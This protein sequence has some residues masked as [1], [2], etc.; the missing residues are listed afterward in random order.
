MKNLSRKR[1]SKLNA[2][3]TKF[4]E[5]A[6]AALMALN[7]EEHASAMK[8]IRLVTNNKMDTLRRKRCPS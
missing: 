5:L 6:F 2:G 7:S 8:I 4:N 3:N 1:V